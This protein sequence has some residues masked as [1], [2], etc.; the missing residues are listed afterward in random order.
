VGHLLG[1]EAH[2]S[3][4]QHLKAAGLAQALHTGM[5]DDASGPGGA[6]FMFWRCEVE[7]TDKGL[8][9]VPY[10]LAAVHQGLQ[11]G[12]Q[13]RGG[14]GALL[15]PAHGARPCLAGGAAPA[16]AASPPRRWPAPRNAQAIC[17]MA[18]EQRRASWGEA[19][20]LHA[21]RFQYRDR[22][23]PLALARALALNLHY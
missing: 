3:V 17:A 6:G 8:Q 4:A 2:G 16:G 21:L 22:Q 14:Q 9:H 10:V 5:A 7:L 12:Q 20:Q 1:H 23:E 19:A 18:P 15:A 13:A 11:V